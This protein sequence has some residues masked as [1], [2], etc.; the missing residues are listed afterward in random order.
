MK[1]KTKSGFVID[2]DKDRATDWRTC[3]SLRKIDSG[4]GSLI[5][6]GITDVVPFLLGEDGE[7]ALMKHVENEKGLVPTQRI[8]EEIKEIIEKLGEDAKKSESSQG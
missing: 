7:A 6:Q 4:D 5:L 2:V 3:K 1:I 8:I